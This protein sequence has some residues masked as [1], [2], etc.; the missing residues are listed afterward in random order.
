MSS[1]AKEDN[2]SSSS[3]APVRP[4]LSRESS[5]SRFSPVGQALKLNLA[6]GNERDEQDQ[7]DE[8][9]ALEAILGSDIRIMDTTDHPRTIQ[10]VVHVTPPDVPVNIVYTNGESSSVNHLSPID[11]YAILPPTYPS[12]SSPQFQLSC[13]WLSYAQLTR[14][15]EKLD[16][17]WSEYVGFPII[18]TWVDWMKSSM[19]SDFGL[20]DTLHIVSDLDVQEASIDDRARLKQSTPDVKFVNVLR[21]NYQVEEAEFLAGDHCCGICFTDYPGTDFFRVPGCGH[22]FCKSCMKTQCS[23]HIKEG[24]VVE[25]KCPET[26]CRYI[27]LP[28]LPLSHHPSY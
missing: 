18:F 23:I 10:V 2:A 17:L 12:L 26:K 24:T 15:C 4:S 16:A 27:F 14:I 20:G 19:W 25:L 21:Y 7:Q 13:D 6:F 1:K 3:S 22:H 9:L 8:M 28:T 11:L 5:A